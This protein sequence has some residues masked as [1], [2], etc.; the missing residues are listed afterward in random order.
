MQLPEL[1]YALLVAQAF[2]ILLGT[3]WAWLRKRIHSG[4]AR[5]GMTRKAAVLAIAGFVVLENQYLPP[6]IGI[7]V[8]VLCLSYFIIAESISIFRYAAL[9][10]VPI[11]QSLRE[12][13]EEVQSELDAIDR[14]GDAN[15]SSGGG[16]GGSGGGKGDGGLLAYTLVDW[17]LRMPLLWWMILRGMRGGQSWRV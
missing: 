4:I 7:D 14:G 10:G 16:G 12:R 13:L 5:R 6:I 2:D 3:L 8:S 15:G 11:P 17:G 1:F 9:L